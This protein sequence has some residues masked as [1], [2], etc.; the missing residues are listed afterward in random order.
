MSM[1]TSVFADSL[2]DKVTEIVSFTEPLVKVLRLMDGEEPAM[3]YIYENMTKAK[4]AIKS[5]YK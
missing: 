2:W 5:F 1:K 4:E 3:G